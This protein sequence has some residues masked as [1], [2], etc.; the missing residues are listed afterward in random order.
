MLCVDSAA[1]SCHL[2]DMTGSWS[3]AAGKSDMSLTTMDVNQL[4]TMMCR[5]FSMLDQLLT[6]SKQCG[7]VSAWP[8]DDGLL[9][10]Y[11]NTC[12]YQV[13]TI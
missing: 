4:R 1:M 13:Y 6:H 7:I 11:Y 3:G 8:G 12:L 2:T 9:D 5:S 10:I